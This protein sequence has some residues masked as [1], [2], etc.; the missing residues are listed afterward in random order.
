MLWTCQGAAQW[1][2]EVSCS[3]ALSPATCELLEGMGW[4]S[5]F[6]HTPKALQGAPLSR[7]AQRGLLFGPGGHVST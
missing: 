3:F 7:E 2:S 5:G 6:S 4:G 1:P